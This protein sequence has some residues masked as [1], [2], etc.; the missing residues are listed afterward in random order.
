MGEYT[1]KIGKKKST[2]TEQFKLEYCQFSKLDKFGQLR[3][4]SKFASDEDI[5]LADSATLKLDNHMNRWKGVCVHQYANRGEIV[6][7]VRSN[8]NW[9]YYIC[10]ASGGNWKIWLSAYWDDRKNFCDITYEDIRQKVKFEATK[11]DY[12]GTQ[13]IPVDNFDT[14]S[15]H[16]GGAMDLALSGYS[17]TQIHKMGRCKVAS[18][19]EYMHKDLACYSGWMLKDM[20]R[21]LGFVKI[22]AGAKMDVL[23]DVK[24]TMIVTDYNTGALVDV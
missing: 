2:H 17:D 16:R 22:A 7:R 5:M 19:K 10:K 24:N 8:G 20:K 14:H 23:V 11:L 4:L 1:V 3:P 9:Y 18:F 12:F 6:C 21:S 13:G 15:L